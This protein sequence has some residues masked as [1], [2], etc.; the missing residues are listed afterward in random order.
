VR[1]ETT[2]YNITLA[3]Q[4]G[5]SLVGTYYPPAEKESPALLLLHMLGS[6]RGAWREFA[7]LA[8]ERGFAALAID[9]R[10]HG[11]SGGERNFGAMDADVDAALSWLSEQEGVNPARIAIAGASIGANLA[12]RGAANHPNVAAVVALSPGLDYR[13]LTTAEAVKALGDRPLLLI[14]AEGDS[15]A[16]DSSRE[17]HNL[18]SK[19]AT[20][21]LYPGNAHGTNMLAADADL[22]GFLLDWLAKNL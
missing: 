20:L 9:L 14:A 7:M 13:G 5:V 11:D 16:A 15:Y 17:L 8:Q 22:T 4:D 12:I 18:S 21:K 3:T 1:L 10:G 19:Q 6:D 2:P